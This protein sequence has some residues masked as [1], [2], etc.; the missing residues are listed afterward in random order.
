MSFGRYIE[1]NPVE[2][3]LASDP[4]EYH[5]S[6]AAHYALGQDNTLVDDNP[7][8][9]ELA[10]D[11]GTRQAHWRDILRS[12]DANEDDIRRAE[13]VL[14]DPVFREQMAERS[15]R[16]TGRKRGR[17]RKNSRGVMRT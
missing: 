5:W 15:G 3:G 7:C 8:I 14:G 6:S 17:P 11:G 13:W 1:R 12:D 4:W 2:A 16:P 9:L 10:S